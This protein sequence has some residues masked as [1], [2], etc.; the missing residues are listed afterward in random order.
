MAGKNFTGGATRCKPGDRAKIIK[1]VCP[2][3]VGLVV[4]VV[5]SYTDGERIYGTTWANDGAAWVVVALGQL[6]TSR[7]EGLTTTEP[8]RTAVLNDVHL[9]PLDDDDPGTGTTT[10]KKKPRAKKKIADIRSVV[11]A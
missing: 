7:R 10:T 1:A 4:C 5:R 8:N 6:I 9:V 3:N 2:E 11:T